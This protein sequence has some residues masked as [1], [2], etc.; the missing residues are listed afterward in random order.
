MT[1]GVEGRGAKGVKELV[2][3]SLAG[4][5]NDLCAV[6]VAGKLAADSL[7]EVCFTE[8]YVAVEEKGVVDIAF[9]FGDFDGCGVGEAVTGADHEVVEAEVFSEGGRVFAGDTWL[10]SDL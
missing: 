8:A 6:V 5:I 7:Q 4:D 10:Q 1:E 3:E 9:A 2:G